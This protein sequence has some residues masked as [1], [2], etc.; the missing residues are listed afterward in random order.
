MKVHLSPEVEM[1]I[2]SRKSIR[3]FLPDAVPREAIERILALSSRA[4]TGVNIQPWKVHV[5]TGDSL[6]RV[7]AELLKAHDNP[8]PNNPHDWEY[9]CYPTKWITPYLERRRKLGFALYSLLGIEKGDKTRMHIQHGR[10]YT[11]FD[12]P[13]GL[14]F[15]IN[16]VLGQA[17]WLDYGMFLQNIMTLARSAG[18]DTCAQA[19]FGMFPRILTPLL[20]LSPDEMVLCGMALGYADPDAPENSLV[21]ERAPVTEFARFHD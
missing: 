2:A 13:V 1:A 10:N 21:S 8:D 16:R 15:T 18:L 6:T 12:A 14:I 20:G 11:F 3:A 9:A 4:P 5:L 19:A 7:S 17:S